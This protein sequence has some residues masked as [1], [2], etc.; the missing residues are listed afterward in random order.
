MDTRDCLLATYILLDAVMAAIDYADDDGC[1][2]L[3]VVFLQLAE[4]A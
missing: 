1:E 4:E 3:D 2:A